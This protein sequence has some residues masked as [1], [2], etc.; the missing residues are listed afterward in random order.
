MGRR[1]ARTIN[2]RTVTVARIIKE[3][4]QEITMAVWDMYN[5]VGGKSDAC[6]TWTKHH[7][8]LADALLFSPDGFRSQR[9]SLHQSLPSASY[10]TLPSS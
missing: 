5:I 8:L 4:A 9:N 3:Y 7:M 6:R 10:V 1:L 2:P